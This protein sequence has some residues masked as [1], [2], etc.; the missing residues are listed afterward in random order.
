MPGLLSAI[1]VVGTILNRGSQLGMSEGDIDKLQQMGS[2]ITTNGSITKLVSNFIIEPVLICSKGVKQ[3]DIFDKLAQVNIDIFTAF[4]MQAFQI[5]KEVY[6]VDARV[7][8]DV[9]STDTGI[10]V[11]RLLNTNMFLGKEEASY[12]T[13]NDIFNSKNKLF[14]LSQ[15]VDGASVSNKTKEAMEE[16]MYGLL[17][18]SIQVCINSKDGKDVLIPVT[19][20]AYVIV[21]TIDNI[22]SILKPNS[23]DKTFD[24]RWDEWRAGAITLKE[25]MFCGDIINEY[26]KNRIKDKDG[27]SAILASRSNNAQWRRAET[28]GIKGFES[29]YNMLLVTAEDKLRLD[30]HIGGNITNET[31]KQKLLTEA[32]AISISIADQDY[33]RVTMLTKDIRGSS[34]IGFK[35]L[36]KRKDK[37]GSELAEFV[38]AFTMG[39]SMTF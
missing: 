25:L 13:Y 2:L 17:Q 19:I 18:K 15:E 11:S 14:T 26:K 34:D 27:L 10:N 8:F 4:Y 24:S 22:I 38:K 20:K 32:E 36:S 7:T 31:Y 5:L 37:D 21:T 6:G 23:E 39:K 28:K 16:T 30:K 29:N 35:S 12:G 1:N 9:L 3:L 33:E